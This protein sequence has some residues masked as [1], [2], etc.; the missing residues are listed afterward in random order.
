MSV[1]STREDAWEGWQ[2][3][4]QLLSWAT[5]AGTQVTLRTRWWEE[6]G[7]VRTVLGQGRNQHPSPRRDRA[8]PPAGRGAEP[9]NPEL[10]AE[11]PCPSWAPC[12]GTHLHGWE[13]C[14]LCQQREL[15]DA[16]HSAHGAGRGAGS[17]ITWLKGEGGTAGLGQSLQEPVSLPCPPL[18]GMCW[19]SAGRSGLIDPQP[20][21]GP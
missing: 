1:L 15:Q 7:V 18:Q 8:E 9:Q 21:G 4:A 5:A 14:S 20:C 6:G 2:V 13:L 3:T 17:G 12:S 16:L 19:M 10:G 11:S